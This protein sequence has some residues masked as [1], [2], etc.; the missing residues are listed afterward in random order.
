MLDVGWLRLK[1]FCCLLSGRHIHAYLQVSDFIWVEIVSKCEANRPQEK[2]KIVDGPVIFRAP[3]FLFY[4][5]KYHQNRRF[6]SLGLRTNAMDVP[7]QPPRYQTQHPVELTWIPV[8]SCKSGDLKLHHEIL[9]LF[10]IFAAGFFGSPWIF[11]NS[12][13]FFRDFV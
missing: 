9:K 4:T 13:Q 11:G 10:G 5:K 3:F 6:G 8:D 1:W 12:E 2:I 7:L